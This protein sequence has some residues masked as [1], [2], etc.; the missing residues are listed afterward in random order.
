MRHSDS[1][2]EMWRDYL[3]SIGED[4]ATT[5]KV[6]TSWHFGDNEQ[7]ASELAALVKAGRKGA[8][9]SAYGVYENNQEPLPVAGDYSVIV[10]WT[11]EAQCIIR[12]TAV[13]IVPFNEV[14]ADFARCEG[15]GDRSLA[16]WRKVHWV[17]FARELQAIGKRPR[18]KM[19]VVCETFEVVY[20]RC[21]DS[22]IPQKLLRGREP[23]GKVTAVQGRRAG[24]R[25]RRT[26]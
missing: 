26:G 3:R 7:S 25:R 19:P 1:A 24:G 4:R 8:T 5:A 2:E 23:R 22:R 9:A 21:P 18:Q 20:G 10:S 15:E 12:T 17:Y 11:G 13:E 14:T 16:Y 6:F